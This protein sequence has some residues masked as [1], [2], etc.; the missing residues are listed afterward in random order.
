M[1]TYVALLR[2]INVG[3]NC[4]VEMKKLATLFES[5]GFE[6]LEPISIAGM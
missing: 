3:G 4:K 6:K 1:N 2:G 5:L